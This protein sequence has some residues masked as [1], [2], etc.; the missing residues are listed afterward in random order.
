MLL[1]NWRR[2]FSGGGEQPQS[3]RRAR[4]GAPHQIRA[5]LQRQKTLGIASTAF[6]SRLLLQ[7]D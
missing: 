3:N 4:C 2:G 1:G 5:K 7:L 6:E